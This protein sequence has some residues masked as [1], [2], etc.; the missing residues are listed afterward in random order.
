MVHEKAAE[1]DQSMERLKELQDTMQFVKLEFHLETMH[2]EI[3]RATA[4][5]VYEHNRVV[6][7]KD[8]EITT[9]TTRVN[10]LEETVDTVIRYASK[11]QRRQRRGADK[12]IASLGAE[13]R[14]KDRVIETLLA[15]IAELELG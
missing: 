10:Q 5:I 2:A 7:L 9:L 14:S 12:K 11:Y 6:G 13:N 4:A 8:R 15:R 1:I 3:R